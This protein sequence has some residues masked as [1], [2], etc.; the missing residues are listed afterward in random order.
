[1]EDQVEEVKRK[2]DIVGVVGKYVALKKSGRHHKG[3]CPFHNEKTPSFVVNEEM[4]LYKCF[5]CGAGGDVIKFLMEIEGVDFRDALERLAE[6]AGVKLISRG[7]DTGGDKQKLLEIMDLTARYYHWQLTEGK[8]GN[9]AREYLADRKINDKLI[10]TFN[11]GYS[12]PGWDHLINYLVKKKGYPELL[13]E[14]AGLISKRSGGGYYDKFRGRIMFPLQD[15]SG[16]V[17]GFTGRILPALVKENEPKY[18]N[19]PETEIYHKGRMLYGFY[20]AR[21]AIR[22]KKKAVLVEGQLDMISSFGAGIPETVAVG[23]TALTE[24]QTELLARLA[25][26]IYLSLDADEAGTTAIKRSA[27]LAEKRGLEIKVVLV[28]GGKDPDEIAR[29][30]PD[31]WKKM[32]ESAVDV[33][34]FVMMKSLQKNDIK[35]PSGIK[36]VTE[37]VLPFL[38][39]IENGVLKEIWTKRLA[40]KLGVDPAILKSE[41][42]RVSSGKSSTEKY[43]NKHPEEESAVE[44][45]TEKLGRRLIGNLLLC[46]EAREKTRQWISEIELPGALGKT[47]SWIL[48]SEEKEPPKIIEMVPP[49]LKSVI[50]D[51]YMTE[52]EEVVEEKAVYNL[53]AQLLREVIREKRKV[54]ISELKLAKLAGNETREEKLSEELNNLDRE[55]SKIMMILE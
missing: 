41:M 25:E 42:E 12:L 45:K 11:L 23:G 19:S 34:E 28:E 32:V 39:K 40:D 46:P 27:E 43:G 20:Q 54:L 37:E 36:K 55:E 4:G 48:N 22:E 26:T 35:S 3:L 49:E 7:F 1:M 31:K 6:K 21:Q 52:G 9:E 51:A 2:T 10:E 30:F 16:K 17:V 38:V 29:K 47:M 8:S 13:L 24:E 18:L 33:Y 15:S 53:V 50:E 44:N 14:K 5:G